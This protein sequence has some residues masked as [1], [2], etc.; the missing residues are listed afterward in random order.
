[1]LLVLGALGDPAAVHWLGWPPG[2]LL[3]AVVVMIAIG[4]MGTAIQRTVVV[5]RMLASGEA[6]E[7]HQD[8]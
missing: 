5:A 1:V 6:R 3:S 8:D 4:T 7:R 2:T